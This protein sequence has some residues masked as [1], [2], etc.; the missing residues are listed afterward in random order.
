MRIDWRKWESVTVT[1]AGIALAVYLVCRY[2]LRLFLPFFIALFIAFLTRPA[3]RYLTRRTGRSQK[4]IAGIVMLLTLFLLGLLLYFL[5]S[6]LLIE[7]QNLLSWLA[8]DSADPNGQ[9]ARMIAFFKGL[10]DR[11]PFLGRLREADFL[12]YFIDDPNGFIAEQLG[13]ILSRFSGAVTGA[14]ASILR[15][16]PSLVLGLLVWVIACFYFAVD[17]DAVTAALS[18]FVPSGFRK[19]LPSWRVHMAEG[20]RRYLRAYFLLFLLTLGEL[21]IGFFILRLE[22]AFLLA[23]LTAILD[24]LPVLGVGTVLLP[25]AILSFAGGNAF[26]GVG[27]LILYGVITVVRQIAEP[28]LVGK[29]LGLH[30]ILMLVSFYTGLK[31]FGVIGVFVG[32]VIAVL[33]KTFAEHRGEENRKDTC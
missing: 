6:R 1:V 16:F 14:V 11:I 7:L 31:L 18:L 25:F 10:L 3:V 17:F 9:I 24:V 33:I 12:K 23:L 19:R 2:A 28:H 32:P 21:L 13:N 27:L 22:Y 26:R 8:E 4:I 15:G 5:C 30:P 29:S 20:L